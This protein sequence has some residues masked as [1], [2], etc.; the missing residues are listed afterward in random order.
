MYNHTLF[1]SLQITRAA[2][3]LKV[4]WAI[5]LVIADGNFN[6]PRGLL[7]LNPV[8]GRPGLP[9]IAVEASAAVAAN[10]GLST[11]GFNILNDDTL[12]SPMAPFSDGY[13]VFFE[14]M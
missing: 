2:I 8:G 12:S 7:W 11:W 5:N 4:K 1:L 14:N 3:K 10:G 9:G 13:S 6:L